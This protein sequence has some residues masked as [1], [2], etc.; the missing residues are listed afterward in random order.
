MRVIET[1]V[2]KFNELSDKAKETARDW[3][4][5]GA[6]NND[7]YDFVYEDA[8]RILN[9]AGFT[10]DK[11]YF[12]GFSSQGDGACFTGSWKADNVKLGEAIKEAPQDK[13][14]L[15]IANEIERITKLWPES[16]MTV[17]HSGHYYHKYETTFEVNSDNKGN[18]EE[19]SEEAII[20][21]SRD[22]MEWIYRRLENEYNFMNEDDQID[23]NI[24]A[25]EY[26][27]EETGNRA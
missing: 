18:L 8:Q 20:E 17:K 7:W 19:G 10:I 4:R 3:Y 22:A 11:I 13:D 24:I 25:N 15:R 16:N 27:F 14:I 23:E 12:S 6:L 2:Y 1:T 9:L 21:V 26:E 5:E